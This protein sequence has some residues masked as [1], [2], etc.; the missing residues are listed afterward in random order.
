MLA[1]LV[2]VGWPQ[3]AQAE[4][5]DLVSQSYR[6]HEL[7]IGC[8]PQFPEVNQTSDTPLSRSDSGVFLNAMGQLAGLFSVSASASGGVTPLSAFVQAQVSAQDFIGGPALAG[9]GA[10]ITFRPLVSDLVLRLRGSEPPGSPCVCI[11][12]TSS[13]FDNTAG[14]AVLAFPPYLLNMPS[15]YNVSLTLDHLYTISASVPDT[16]GAPQRGVT[17]S[18]APATV[19]ESESTLTFLV[20]GLGALLLVAR[21]Q[22]CRPLTTPR[23]LKLR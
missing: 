15:A 8:C 22:A 6:I 19:P 13:L 3:F 10:M 14:L 17:L 20:V 12:T 16:M 1:L 18:I 2:V 5:I 9:A 23:W 21:P 7:A 11:G 4:F